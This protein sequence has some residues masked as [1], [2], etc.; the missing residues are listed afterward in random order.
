VLKHLSFLDEANSDSVFDPSDPACLKDIEGRCQLSFLANASVLLV[1][2]VH[3]DVSDGLPLPLGQLGQILGL[4]Y[5]CF[6]LV[7]G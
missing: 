2:L 6:V 1:V 3:S 7:V 4:I 5:E